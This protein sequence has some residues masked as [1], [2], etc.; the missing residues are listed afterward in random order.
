M[1]VVKCCLTYKQY[2]TSAPL[3]NIS[4]KGNKNLNWYKAEITAITLTA[5]EIIREIEFKGAGGA[6]VH[7]LAP[8]LSILRTGR[9]MLVPFMSELE[10]MSAAGIAGTGAVLAGA[11]ATFKTIQNVLKKHNPYEGN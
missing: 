6:T 5:V 4:F 1:Q 11:V 7:E 10:Q 9:N 2:N 3:T 8:L